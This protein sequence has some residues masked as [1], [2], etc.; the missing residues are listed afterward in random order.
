M[1]NITVSQYGKIA[2]IQNNSGSAN[3]AAPVGGIYLFASGA[4]GASKLYMNK[5]GSTDKYEVGSADLKIAADS[6][7][8]STVSIGKGETLTIAGGTGLDTSVSGQTI[9]FAVDLGE[10]TDE[11]LAV[12]DDYIV[13]LDGGAT[14]ATKKEAL[15]DVVGNMAGDGLGAASGVLKVDVSDFAGSGLEDDGSENLRIAAAAAGN[16][17]AGGA[18]SALSVNVDGVGIEID[19]D[20]LRLK[21]LGVVTDKLAADAVTEAKLADNSVVNAN[22]KSDAAIAANKLDF[23][24]D[25]GGNVTFGNQGNDTVT[26]TGHVNVAQALT[27]AFARIEY[28]DVVKL[29]SVVQTDTTLEVADKLIVAAVSASSANSDGGGLKIGGGHNVAGNASI[30]YDHNSGTPQ[31]DFNIGG[32]TEIK[33]RAG[34]ILPEANND[35]DLGS[36]AL[37]FKDLY[38]DGVA[39]LDSVDIDAGA[40][41]GATLGANSAVTIT[42]A[43]MNGGSIDGVAIGAS[44]PSSGKFTTVSGSGAATFAST[45]TAQGNILPLADGV[46]DLGGSSKEF[47]DLYIDGVA[48]IDSLQADQLGAA[49]DA[50]SQA[51]TNINVDSG[52]IDG[53]VIGANSAAAGTFA[54]LVAGGD[55]DLGDATSDTITATGRF[56]SDLVP[57]TDSARALGTSALQ[58]SAAHIDVG[59]IDQ[60]GSALDANS[61]AITNVDIN[62]GAIDG[63]TIGANS[64]ANGNFAQ[65]TSSFGLKVNTLPLQVASNAIWGSAGSAIGFDGSANVSIVNSAA[66]G[67]NLTVGGGFGD[68]GLTLGSGGTLQMDG[69][70]T[71]GS[72]A[73]FRGN[74]DFSGSSNTAPDVTFKQDGDQNGFLRWDSSEN[75]LYLQYGSSGGNGVQVLT[76]GGNA[77]TDYAIDVSNGSNNINKV[78]AGAFV[79]YSDESLKQDVAS[80][81]N[82]ALDTVMSL[83]GVEFTWKDSGERDFGFIA[84]D[85]QNVLPKAVHVADDGVQGVDYSRLT[86][87]LVEAVKAQQVQIDD[88]KKVITNLKK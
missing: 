42:N 13:F 57:S 1:S 70:L 58:W 19:S 39:Y 31:L 68:T 79:T 26:F 62:S 54:A 40:I 23:N 67:T 32:T 6:G 74:V 77:T 72:T 12:A 50:N 24:V 73:L 78:R 27:A 3:A 2:S 35:I 80:M 43:D 38:I 25:L 34:A 20:T 49:L 75:N 81:S 14:G 76:I 65:L 41:D 82:T 56:D 84:Q 46:V 44:S 8:D 17:L 18:G 36:D 11:T 5:E 83:E 37:E 47:K 9:T 16:G 51:I 86:S 21:D 30:L 7:S 15:A 29:N 64:A 71:A 87:V 55:V 69:A 61:Q 28:L 4:A 33:L 59:H 60:L 85:V 45:V 52:A 48:Y 66:V 63:T 22:V 53:A 88:L 10:L